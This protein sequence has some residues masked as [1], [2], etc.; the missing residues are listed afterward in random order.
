LSK[1]HSALGPLGALDAL[2]VLSLSHRT[3]GLPALGGVV[4]GG[5]GIRLHA[6]LTTAGIEAVVLS[7]CNRFEIYWRAAT[8]A[9][10]RTV[11]ELVEAALPLAKDLL[12]EGSIQLCGD[13]AARHLFRVCSGLESMVLGEAEILGQVRAA[14]E[15][16]GAGTFLR[17][18]FTAAIRTGRGARA[19]TGI[20]AGAMSV[21]SA[22]V[23][24]LESRV[25][26]A[27]SRVLVIGAGE[28]SAKVVR[29]LAAIGVGT[30]V[31]A[32]RTLDKAESLASAH[33]G[34]AAGLDTVA[35]E[36][37]EAQVVVC[38][39]YSSSWMVTRAHLS[40]RSAARPV[41]LV[42]LSMPPAIEPF[43]AEGVTRI[44]LAEIERATAAHR[45]RREGEVPRVEAFI[46][47]E[48][49]WLRAWA[50]QELLRPFVST[51]RQKA[52]SIRREELER[53]F[54]ELKG[55][56]PA[57]VMERFSRRMF[58][59]LLSVPLDQLKSGDLPFDGPSADYL[60]R[61]FALDRVSELA[62][63]GPKSEGES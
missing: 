61:L 18:V 27:T 54:E 8:I 40:D 63:G 17:G 22:A 48:L 1:S 59:R 9:E 25:P 58:D 29:Q 43:D 45:R 15:Q 41:V 36:I 49:E 24:Q 13:E 39:A 51:L 23:Q 56:D 2:R 19:A 47:R 4:A 44:D 38:A 37:A 33:G 34:I 31:V 12:K 7:T 28:T 14:M 3:C 32:N 35:A 10:D 57:R 52:D 30:L 11:I 50:R 60:R 16:S 62:L 53:A 26:L 6:S 55:D 42:D 5:D 21:A 20:A 46:D